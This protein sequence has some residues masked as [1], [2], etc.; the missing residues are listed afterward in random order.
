MKTKPKKQTKPTHSVKKALKG[1]T[2]K[3]AAPKKA[4]EP[5]KE[6]LV[7]KRPESE[8]RAPEIV[9]MQEKAIMAPER[10]LKIKDQ[11]PVP[12]APPRFPGSIIDPTEIG[13]LKA[14]MLVIVRWF[15]QGVRFAGGRIEK[16]WLRERNKKGEIKKHHEDKHDHA[17]LQIFPALSPVQTITLE[18]RGRHFMNGPNEHSL[19]VPT[20]PESA[21]I[22]IAERN[23]IAFKE[24]R[25]I[26]ASERLPGHRPRTAKT[27]SKGPSAPRH[28]ISEGEPFRPGS[29]KEALYRTLQEKKALSL[30]EM[31]AIVVQAGRSAA[32]VGHVLTR[33]REMNL[34]TE[35]GDKI[36]IAGKK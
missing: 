28:H 4:A 35:N 24:V 18:S 17:T 8:T 21:S 32:L 20:V 29:A 13:T 23:A 11:I 30:G 14:G 25:R 16:V 15:D 27:S 2:T 31:K 1:L 26:A 22:L 6:A 36:Q 9:V 12:E 10:Y 7:A 5:I 34:I 19:I 33:L 3:K